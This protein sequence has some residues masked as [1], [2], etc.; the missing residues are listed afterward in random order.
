MPS[1]KARDRRLR[2]EKSAKRLPVGKVLV[3]NAGFTP[4]NMA[5]ADRAM[6]LVRT[7]K[8]EPV[9]D[10]N[11]VTPT[12]GTVHTAS[13]DIDIPAVIRLT[14]FVKVPDPFAV[15]SAKGVFERDGYVCQYCGKQLDP[16]APHN[17]P[18]R[19]T[20]DHIV[21]KRL[22]TDKSKASTWTNTCT[23]CTDCNRRKGGI[24]PKSMHEAGMKFYDPNF[25]P[26]RP[27]GDFLRRMDVANPVQREWIKLK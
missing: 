3:L 21:P 2:Q 1:T 9:T 5:A 14:K 11:G 6:Y 12:L 4:L 15:W 10:A 7:H 18:L 16:H 24:H 26:K 22:F 19:A 8:A 23:A 17:S 13:A 25:E 20:V 27:R